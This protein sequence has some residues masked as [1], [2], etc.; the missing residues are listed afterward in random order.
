MKK[1]ISKEKFLR[2]IVAENHYK[3]VKINGQPHR[4][5]VPTATRI[6]DVLPKLSP[7]RRQ[8]FLDLPW[9]HILEFTFVWQDIDPESMHKLDTTSTMKL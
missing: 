6:L 8:E 9:K 1:G 5:D 3:F 7:P 2:E 4:I